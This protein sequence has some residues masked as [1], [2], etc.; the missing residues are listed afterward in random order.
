M[1][2]RSLVP[3]HSAGQIQSPATGHGDTLEVDTKRCCNELVE[4]GWT[5][6]PFTVG[7]WLS[8]LAPNNR[9]VVFS[10]G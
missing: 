8:S 2:Q 9:R 10:T 1:H 4:E 7:L 5:S 6:T 3:L